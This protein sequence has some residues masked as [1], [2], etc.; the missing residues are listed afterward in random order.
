MKEEFSEL[1]PKCNLPKY[2]CDCTKVKAEAIKK[3]SPEM[4]K[5]E[6][7]KQAQDEIERGL[8][9]WGA[10]NMKI[11]WYSI[12][13]EAKEIMT[14]WKEL[15]SKISNSLEKSIK[16]GNFS[17][18]S[19]VMG[20]N[21]HEGDIKQIVLKIENEAQEYNVDFNN[22]A[23]KLLSIGLWLWREQGGEWSGERK[24]IWKVLT[25]NSVKLSSFLDKEGAPSC[26]DTS[27]LIKVLA[28]Q[29]GIKGEV[30]KVR[31]G[32]LPHRYFKTESGKIMDY[33]WSR[34]T[35]GLK[36]NSGAFEKV[37]SKKVKGKPCGIS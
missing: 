12:E 33:W 14:E 24:I 19:K 2:T 1:C 23:K 4:T 36:L 5:E 30:E 3:Q 6:S 11:K 9:I 35:A 15:I 27:Y 20:E 37:K 8:E 21:F 17:E 34:G 18:L 22:E 7:W 13:G 28:D 25:E 26:V 31:E 16:S 10:L 32:R 29:F